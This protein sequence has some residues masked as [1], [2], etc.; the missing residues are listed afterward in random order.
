VEHG[1]LQGTE[2]GMTPDFRLSVAIPVFNEEETFPLLL[3]RLLHVLDQVAGGPHEIVF[4]DDGSTDGT[5][6]LLREAARDSRIVAVALSRNFGHQAALTAALDHVTGDATVVM[7]AD[8][9]DVPE[10]IPLFVEH[11]HAGYDVVYAQR[12]DRKESVLLRFLY[13]AYYR[14]AA[15]LSSSHL[16]L[17]AGDF[18]LMSRRVVSLLRRMPERHRYLRG[19]RAW[20][21]FR[22]IGVPVERASREAGRSKYSIYS[23]LKLAFDGIFAFSVVPLRAAAF[24]GATAMAASIMFGAY[25]LFARFF[26]DQTPRGFTALILTLIFLSGVQLFFL[27][28]IGEYLGRLYEEAKG[29]PL[30]VVDTVTRSPEPSERAAAGQ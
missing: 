19:L 14:L 3:P 1:V 29:R 6:D 15:G 18:G 22:Q 27:G 4:V 16:P 20:A 26:L 23:L 10:A 25:S 5:S 13:F 12:V 2:I 7:D 11:F 30:Y 9:Q 8:L 21:G 24:L 28:V 17:D